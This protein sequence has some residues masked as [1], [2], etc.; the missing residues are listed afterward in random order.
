ML[1]YRSIIH[2]TTHGLLLHSIIVFP[3][4]VRSRST[5]TLLIL[6][7]RSLFQKY[8]NITGLINIELRCH[9]R[10]Y[11]MIHPYSCNIIPVCNEFT[12]LITNDR[13]ISSIYSDSTEI[14][15]YHLSAP[16]RIHD[17]K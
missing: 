1:K 6:E 10:P 14:I 9:K 13:C 5:L 16:I 11:A 8:L 2:I 4:V 17:K 7:I 12:L 15:Q 3:S